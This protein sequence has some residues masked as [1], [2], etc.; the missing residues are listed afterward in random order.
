[1]VSGR[2]VNDVEYKEVQRTDDVM[3]VANFTVAVDTGYG[4]YERTHFIAAKTFG[5]SAKFMHQYCVKGDL[6]ELQGELNQEKWD[7]SNGESGRVS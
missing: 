2:L 4:D 5:S 3:R 1:V 7:S 6:V